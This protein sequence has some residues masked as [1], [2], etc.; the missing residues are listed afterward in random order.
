[1]RNV[2]CM[3]KVKSAFYDFVESGKIGGIW[4]GEAVVYVKFNYILNGKL[5]DQEE[6]EFYH[7]N[8]EENEIEYEYDDSNGTVHLLPTL[9]V[10]DEE[11]FFK[12]LLS[13]LIK[14]SEIYDLQ[15]LFEKYGENYIIQYLIITIFGSARY[16]DYQNPISY[17]ERVEKYLED[18]TFSKYKN[19]TIS[20]NVPELLYSK[21]VI[22]NKL[23]DLGY[24]T[25]YSFE[26]SLELDGEK[27]YLPV[28]NYAIAD[29]KCYI[30]SIQ[31]KKIN[32]EN[33]YQKK[34]KRLLYKVYETSNLEDKNDLPVP[35][36]IVVLAIFMKILKLNGISDL[37]IITFLPDRYFEKKAV[38]DKNADKIQ[39]NL[40][41]KLINLIYQEKNIFPGIEINYP[42]YEGYADEDFGD[43]LLIRLSDLSLCNNI[44]LS[45]IFSKLNIDKINEDKKIL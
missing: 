39:S 34:L 18:I 38:N 5:Y 23:D 30:Y 8:D 43:D 44:F 42:L 25:P 22:N 21:I 11:K 31:N 17:L 45:S 37:R 29:N 7:G 10:N 32:E 13:C 28:I 33:T 26:I 41:Q 27:F 9:I 6:D 36:F 16:T 1:M 24:E 35:S 40:T 19:T 4:S 14:Y 20:D 15:K 2:F 12:K 3:D